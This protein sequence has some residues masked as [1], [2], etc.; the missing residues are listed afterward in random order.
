MFP[1]LVRVLL[2]QLESVIAVRMEVVLWGLL[3]ATLDGS[4]ADRA[5]STRFRLTAHSNAARS[6]AAHGLERLNLLPIQ[7][8]HQTICTNADEFPAKQFRYSAN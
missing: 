5:L 7:H 3:R 2:S 6:C 8:H 4:R 1:N